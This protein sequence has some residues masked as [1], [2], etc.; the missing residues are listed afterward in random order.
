MKRQ[1]RYSR[2]IATLLMAALG[3]VGLSAP[4]DAATVRLTVENIGTTT[5][6]TPVFAAFHDGSYNI[7]QIGGTATA[8]LESLAEVGVN[9]TISNE[10]GTAN[11]RVSDST[12]GPLA[13]G[14]SAFVDFTI[15]T[16]GTSNSFLSLA[17]MVLP[18]SDYIFGTVAD[19]GD[20]V[21]GVDL[22]SLFTTGSQTFTLSDVYDVGTE[23]NDFVTGA[24]PIPA[25]NGLFVGTPFEGVLPDSNPPTGVVEGGTIQE[26]DNP[27]VGFANSPFAGSEPGTTSLQFTLT[28]VTAV[29]EPSMALA[30]CMMMGTMVLRRRKRA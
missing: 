26:I 30:G 17:T 27:F 14:G 6:I 24:P 15:D 23:V 20:S 2:R 10:F 18:S 28:T 7:A 5:A 25:A 11:G 29:P 4:A 19:A 8:G 22:T 9:T 16:T 1:L 3:A 21:F 12:A 13:A